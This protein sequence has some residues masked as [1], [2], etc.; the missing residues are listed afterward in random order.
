[1]GTIVLLLVVAVVAGLAFIRF[2]PSDPARWHVPVQG[3]QNKDGAKS[4]LRVL[5]AE[6]GT[7]MRVHDAMMQMSRTEVLAGDPAAGAVTYITR[8]KLMGFPDYTTAEQ[9]GHML[10]VF[11]RSRFGNSDLGVNRRRLDRL[12]AMIEAG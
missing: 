5:S 8:S 4:A 2:A 1:M 9:T 7:L 10:K 3:A 12:L 11:S 6:E